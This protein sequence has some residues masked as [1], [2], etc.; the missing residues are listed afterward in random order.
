MMSDGSRPGDRQKWLE[1]EHLRVSE[2]LN[3]LHEVIGY[4]ERAPSLKVDEATR[5][6]K[7][8]QNF[9]RR[10]NDLRWL[11]LEIQKLHGDLGID[12]RAP[13]LPDEMLMRLWK[14]ETRTI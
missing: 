8:R 1:T 7:Y 13:T 12:D 14:D 4:M 6:D 5:L 9:Q 2:L 10:Q 11:E 3:R